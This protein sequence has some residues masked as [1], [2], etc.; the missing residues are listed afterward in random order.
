ML[1]YW[2]HMFEIHN[3][4]PPTQSR[5]SWIDMIQVQPE[6]EKKKLKPNQTKRIELGWVG[7]TDSP[8]LPNRCIPPYLMYI[9][10]KVRE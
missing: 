9:T 2:A 6:Q 7:L 1:L 10:F 5:P 4:L 8:S 3:P